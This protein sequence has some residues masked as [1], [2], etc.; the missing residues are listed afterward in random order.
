MRDSY[1]LVV[2]RTASKLTADLGVAIAQDWRRR[3]KKSEREILDRLWPVI[4]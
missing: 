2:A 3:P 1:D 4:V